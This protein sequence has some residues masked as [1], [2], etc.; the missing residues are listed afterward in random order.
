MET[1]VIP[2]GVTQLEGFIFSGC[3]SLKTVSL[4]LGL[5]EIGSCLFT[6]CSS[7]EEVNIPSDWTQLPD[8]IF[9]HSGIQ[10]FTVPDHITHL[11]DGVFGGCYELTKLVIPASVTSMNEAFYVCFALTDIQYGGT[12]DQWLALSSKIQWDQGLGQ[13]VIHCADGNLYGKDL[14]V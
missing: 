9:Q 5:T 2:A 6:L 1:I 8:R 4:P 7:L 12:K 13:V 3:S 10:Q 14:Q 11:E